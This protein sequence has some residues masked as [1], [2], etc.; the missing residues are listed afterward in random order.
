MGDE[1]QVQLA[2]H[3]TVTLHVSFCPCRDE[4]ALGD[5]V[6]VFACSPASLYC[7]TPSALPPCRDELAVGEEVQV[8]PCSAGHIF[9]PPCLAPWL[10]QHNSCPTCRSVPC[11]RFACRAWFWLP[12]CCAALTWPLHEL[13]Q[14]GSRGLWSHQTCVSCLPSP[15]NKPFR[16]MHPCLTTTTALP[17]QPRAPHRRPAV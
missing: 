6:Q 4:L 17:M 5:E 3:V 14:Q 9:H 8:M 10:E 1:L 13:Q 12:S 11:T 7:D 2:L 16:H 15:P